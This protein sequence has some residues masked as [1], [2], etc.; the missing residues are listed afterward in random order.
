MPQRGGT[1]MVRSLQAIIQFT[2]HP[3]D[4]MTQGRG[5]MMVRPL[6]EVM[7]RNFKF[8]KKNSMQMAQPHGKK[9]NWC[10]WFEAYYDPHHIKIKWCTP[11]KWFRPV[12]MGIKKLSC[13][14][15]HHMESK[16]DAP[17]FWFKL[18]AQC[19]HPD[20]RQTIWLLKQTKNVNHSKHKKCKT[21]GKKMQ[22]F[23][24]LDFTKKSNQHR[25]K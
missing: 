22:R 24:C 5:R 9:Y 19:A 15:L 7:L 2:V 17:L 10:K 12:F 20:G 18:R 6:P 3:T 25:R 13:Y 23:G 21:Y 14:H 11:Y 1:R 8:G 16:N 4:L